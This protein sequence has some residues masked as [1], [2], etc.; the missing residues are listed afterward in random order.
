[1]ISGASAH[2]LLHLPRLARAIANPT[3]TQWTRGR[4]VKRNIVGGYTHSFL[5]KEGP[6][7]VGLSQIDIEALRELGRIL[8]R[9]SEGED[10]RLL[11]SQ[12]RR[13]KPKKTGEHQFTA[14]ACWSVRALNPSAKDRRPL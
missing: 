8:T 14:M 9:V 3:R 1:M 12:N 2:L 7:S 5:W 10:A 13:G 11:F 6:N 4:F